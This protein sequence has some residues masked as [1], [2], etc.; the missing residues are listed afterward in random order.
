MN[1]R[2]IGKRNYHDGLAAEQNV[3]RHYQDDGAEI[4]AERWRGKSGE[5]DLIMRK[6]PEIIFVEVKKASDF[7]RAAE[8]V[9]FRQIARISKAAEEF[10]ANEP[11][12]QFTSVRIDV[13]LVN[14]RGERHILENVTM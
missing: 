9:T 1:R 10:L 2:L 14:G 5:I 3:K 7:M 13:A 4:A 12:G 8:R 6:G 11:N